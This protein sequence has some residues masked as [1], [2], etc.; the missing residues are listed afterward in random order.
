MRMN[1][2][3]E[4]QDVPG[5]LVSVLSPIGD[6]G[7][8]LV[9]I[10]HQRKVKNEK[11]YIPVQITIEGERNNLN[12]VLDKFDEMGINILEKDDVILKQ[13][14]STILIGDVIDTDVR[15]T[16]D[17]INVL[18]G[19]WVVGLDIKLDKPFYRNN[20]KSLRMV[21]K[22]NDMSKNDKLTFYIGNGEAEHV[23][24]NGDMKQFALRYDITSNSM[25]YY[26]VVCLIC[27]I[28]IGIL[29]IVMYCYLFIANKN[30]KSCRVKIIY[31]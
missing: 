6:L 11:G 24:V 18:D 22:F 1:L 31:F 26:S 10:I 16:L 27:A 5:Q 13:R 14:I 7:A 15:D 19:V 21:M 9:T 4:I 30:Y 12:A 8:N 20:N 25:D 3:L 17:R 28:I 2:V 23:D 29:I